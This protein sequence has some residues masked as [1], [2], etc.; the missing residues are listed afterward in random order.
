MTRLAFICGLHRS[1]TTLLEQYLY[2]HFEVKALR[3]AVPENEGQFLQDLYKPA[4]HYG[5]PG[6]F[7]FSQKMQDDLRAL[8]DFDRYSAKILRSWSKHTVG[9]GSVLL[10][11]S[12]PNITKMWWLRKVFPDAIFIVW[13]RDPRAV[14][15][16]T[17]KWS[18]TS[19]EELMQHW[20]AAYSIAKD[21]INSDTIVMRYE[22]FCVS[23]ES[24][25]EKSGIEHFLKRREKPIELAERFSTISNTNERYIRCFDDIIIGDGVWED[26]GYLS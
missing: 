14:S 2:S 7:A 24:C 19:L 26:F 1:G 8:T 17:Q 10:E 23:P 15:G 4:F 25:L 12:P 13:T 21:D 22:D 20:N 3:A 9:E 11:K 16:A 18:K 6:R 5:G